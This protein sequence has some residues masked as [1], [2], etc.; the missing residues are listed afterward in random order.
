MVVDADALVV[1]GL[2][3][4][5][6][7]RFARGPAGAAPADAPLLNPA[8]L[9]EIAAARTAGRD[10]W[11][12][13]GTE[14]G[15]PDRLAKAAGATGSLSLEERAGPARAAALVARF[16]ARSF[17]Y[18]GGARRDLSAWKD[19]RSA[20]GVD[21]PVRLARE[22]RALRGDAR[23][24]PGPGGGARDWIRSLRPHHWVKSALVFAPLAAAHETAFSSWALAAGVFAAFSALASGIYLLNDLIDLPDDRR[25][26]EKRRRPLAS[27]RIP[28]LSA[29]AA[30]AVLSTGAVAAAFA[31]SAAAGAAFLLYLGGALA[32]SLRLKRLLFVDAAALAALYALRVAAGAAAL[33]I[34]LSPWFLEFFLFFF[35]AL[36]VVKRVDELRAAGDSR[37]GSGGRAYVVDDLVVVIAVCVASGFA[38]AVVMALWA[39][40][41]RA[42][43]LYARPGMLLLVAPLSVCW[44]GRV[45]LLANRGALGGDPVAFAARDR[46]SWLFAAAA[47]ALFAA[48]I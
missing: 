28:P 3:L 47:A 25:H 41:L 17:D 34:P 32:Y 43:A 35:F 33:S 29:L 15:V 19:A 14:D 6:A 12:V 5:R 48:A 44:L 13:S 21:P 7:L 40:S 8:L 18:A 23:L 31:L 26:P 1:G 39:E 9:D 22:L 27:G 46:G 20:I 10:V 16:G 11:I 2:A 24:L 42:G 30:A 45:V 37:T 36:A 4:E 38:A